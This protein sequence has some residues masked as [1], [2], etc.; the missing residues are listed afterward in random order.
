M[1]IVLWEI[2]I[3][4]DITDQWKPSVTQNTTA[5]HVHLCTERVITISI[6]A[7]NFDF[8]CIRWTTYKYNMFSMWGTRFPQLC[9]VF[10]SKIYSININGSYHTISLTC[11]SGKM[12]G[13]IAKGPQL[14]SLQ[15]NTGNI[16]FHAGVTCFDYWPRHCHKW[17]CSWFPLV[18]PQLQNSI[19]P[20]LGHSHF[21]ILFNLF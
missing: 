1:Q 15:H 19:Y 6:Q 12:D 5:Q 7:A 21:H 17:C 13:D 3:A 14:L 11:R 16:L 18:L 9:H 2:N 20:I 10:D 8:I 4:H